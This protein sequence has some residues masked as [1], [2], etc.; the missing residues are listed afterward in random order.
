M[1]QN[2]S[3]TY[4]TLNFS[5]GWKHHA[6]SNDFFPRQVN[7]YTPYMWNIL[8]YSA[9]NE[10]R[11][12]ASC[13]SNVLLSIYQAPWRWTLL[14]RPPVV[15]L[16]KKF[17]AYYET[18]RFI[19]VLKAPHWSPSSARLIQSIPIHPICLRSILTP[20][21]HLRLGL[22]IGLFLS[23]FPANILC[24]VIPSRDTFS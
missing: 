10:G 1:C 21:N 9:S 19:I 4:I 8:T 6:W 22:P 7:Y 3:I 12:S 16:L 24:A 2:L 5:K 11:H 14:L 17:P 15:R 13:P 20:C 23:G 18:R